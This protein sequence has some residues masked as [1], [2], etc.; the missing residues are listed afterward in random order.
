MGLLRAARSTKTARYTSPL[1]P[2][3]VPGRV[4]YS[5]LGTGAPEWVYPEMETAVPEST[6]PVAV[7]GVLR[8][9]LEN[10]GKQQ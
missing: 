5:S 2:V 1:T 6:A 3:G 8:L 7:S 10:T 4:F 9:A